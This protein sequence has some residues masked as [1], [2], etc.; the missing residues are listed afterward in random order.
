MSLRNWAANQGEVNRSFHETQT[1]INSSLT[2]LNTDT[3]SARVG[4]A[5]QWIADKGQLWSGYF[6]AKSEALT[7]LGNTLGQM[8][9]YYGMAD[10]QVGG[11]K[12][13]KNAKR[14][15]RTARQSGRAF[16]K[17]AR[18]A[19]DSWES[20]GVDDEIMNWQGQGAYTGAVNNNQL[21]SMAAGPAMSKP[22]G[23]G[24]RKWNA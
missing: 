10:E 1:S 6:D 12:N 19:S 15:Q 3:K 2:D 4:A 8:S 11:K 21:G 24:L 17:A 7:Q 14:Q 22:E 23:A 13:K 16:E 18:V 5:Q 9:E 20:P